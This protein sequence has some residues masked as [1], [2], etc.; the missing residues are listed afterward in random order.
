MRAKTSPRIR[1]IVFRLLTVCALATLFGSLRTTDV[2]IGAAVT[3]LNPQAGAAARTAETIR[4]QDTDLELVAMY[5]VTD[6]QLEATAIPEHRR[7][8]VLAEDTLPADALGQI[9]QL[10]IITDGPAR[11]LGM[12]HRSTTERDSWILS[13]DPSESPDVLQRTLVHELAHLY[14]LREAD[15]TSQRTNCAGELMEIGCAHTQSLLADYARQFWS[16]VVEPA[17]YVSGEYVTQYAADS[18][19]E[20][21]AE[22]FMAWVY[23]DKADSPTIAA[24][25]QW[26]DERDIFVSARTEIRANLRLA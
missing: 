10:N 1:R 26:F 24:K 2:D 19:H 13:I 14:T 12:V 17:G 25:Y 9:R 4:Y 16:G 21:L 23:T 20:D 22:T 11:T 3:V 8:W 5:R 18:V 7:I 15:L 6:G